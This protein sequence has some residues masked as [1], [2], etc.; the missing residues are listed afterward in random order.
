MTAPTRWLVA[1]L[2]RGATWPVILTRWTEDAARHDL[3]NLTEADVRWV[4]LT[5]HVGPNIRVIH[6]RGVR[7]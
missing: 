2:P 5:E 1:Y 4:R 6:E 7:P 3:A